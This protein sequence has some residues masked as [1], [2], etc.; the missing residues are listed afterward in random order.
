VCN[1]SL[2][3]FISCYVIFFSFFSTHSILFHFCTS[4]HFVSFCFILFHFVSFCFILF[5]FV[6]F[7]FILFHYFTLP[8]LTLP[9]LTLPYL[10][11][12]RLA[13]SSS[14]SEDIASGIEWMTV[15]YKFNRGIIHDGNL[16]HLASPITSIHSSSVHPLISQLR[17]SETPQMSLG[18]SIPAAAAVPHNGVVTTGHQDTGTGVAGAE[19]GAGRAA[20]GLRRVIL[21]FN[22]FPQRV[23]ECCRRAT[24]HSGEC[25]PHHYLTF[26][27]ILI[28]HYLSFTTITSP[29]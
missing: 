15:P 10:I 17:T 6:S 12:G 16:P 2:L 23:D 20:E 18:S 29:A 24:E 21:G 1:S 19:A 27:T 26:T 28:H 5:H 3:F 8:Y 22:C 4:F 14:L 13:D 11:P 25:F 9:Y 7:C